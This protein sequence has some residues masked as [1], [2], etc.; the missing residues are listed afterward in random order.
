[1]VLILWIK[2][3]VKKKEIKGILQFA[4][5]GNRISLQD[6]DWDED[7]EKAALSF[8]VDWLLG[9]SNATNFLHLKLPI[10]CQNIARGVDVITLDSNKIISYFN[11]GTEDIDKLL[12]ELC[13]GHQTLNYTKRLRVRKDPIEREFEYRTLIEYG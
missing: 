3:R 11:L 5:M 9:P 12:T 6:W 8:H 1:M 7:P 2:C 13:D 10:I 4:F